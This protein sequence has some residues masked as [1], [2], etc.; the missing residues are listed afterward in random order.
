MTNELGVSNQFLDE[1]RLA[2]NPPRQNNI[3]F[4]YDHSVEGER[5]WK[6]LVSYLAS[7]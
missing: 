2:L 3:E 1:L 4:L 7:T 5:Q 6:N